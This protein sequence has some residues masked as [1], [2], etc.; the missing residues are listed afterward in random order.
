MDHLY[1]DQ[2]AHPA[3]QQGEVLSKK[4]NLSLDLNL[5]RQP[6][7]RGRF[8][9]LG[10]GGDVPLLSSPDLHKL[11]IA[12]PDLEKIIMGNG[13]LTTATP[14]PNTASILFPRTVTEEQENFANGFEAALSELQHSDSSQGAPLVENVRCD[15]T[16]SGD[17]SEDYSSLLENSQ[18]ATFS[19]SYGLSGIKEEQR[20]PSLGSSPPMSPIDMVTQEKAKLE[21]KRQ[22]NRLAASK[23]RRR[24]LEKIAKLEDKVKL[25]K[26][27]NGDL[28]VMVNKLKQQVFQLKE[29]VLE[30]ANHGCDIRDMQFQLQ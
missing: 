12:T 14:T 26:N 16:S 20:V 22:R 3:Q 21:R 29:Q 17:S 4:R 19:N 2:G 11:G 7:K 1:M 5:P 13:S 28:S 27:E 6:A 10:L 8:S 25:L 18:G 30:H 23:C 15:S 24:K 9:N